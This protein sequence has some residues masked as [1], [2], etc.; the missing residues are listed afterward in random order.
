MPIRFIGRQRQLGALHTFY[1]SERTH[2]ATVRGRRRVGKSTLLLHSLEAGRSA[3]HQAA[4]LTPES[5]Y[6]RFHDDMA[7]TLTPILQPGTASDILHAQNWR[8]MILALGQ[9]ATELGRL[10]VV[11]DEFPYL[12]R[13]DPSLE[14]VL[15]E[16]L[17][18]I[19]VLDQPLK[20]ILCGSSIS[21]MEALLEHSSP[22]HGRSE[23][24]LVLQPLD[25][26]ESAQFTPAWSPEHLVQART[27]FGGMPRYLS[28]LQ[29][30]LS[31]GENYERLVL[32]PD[33]PLHEETNRLLSAELSEPRIYAS[34]LMAISR[35]NTKA[36]EII[37]AAGIHAS[38]LQKYLGRLEELGLVR[39][40][41]S[42]NATP[43]TRNLRYTLAD[44]FIASWYRYALPHLSA[45]KIRGGE[46]AWERL[47]APGINEDKNAA[48]ETFENICRYWT[49]LYMN[50]FWDGEHSEVGQILQGSGDQDAEI[51]VACRLGHGQQLSWLLGECK[52][53][54]QPQGTRTLHQLHTNARKLL[55]STPVRQW[56][57][58]SKN[59][60]REEFKNAAP[61]QTRL[62][63]LMELYRMP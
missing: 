41:R 59:G 49:T 29:E 26:L 10:S 53:T 54:T 42:A 14:S 52:W 39:S 28:Q 45:L 44:P 46:G 48:P 16:V 30:D 21:Q 7:G 25:H 43:A 20:L 35:G 3:Y 8:S 62:I 12:S 47:V 33:G 32:N 4:Q 23:L 36:G 13:S 18:R 61:E 5:N 31:I 24:N 6:A 56:L 9:A 17:G 51:D 63:D 11:I 55:G 38:S 27:V 22:L 37:S 60:F 19:E 1:A 34:I 58:F 2:L 40:M 15:Q 50:E 57:V